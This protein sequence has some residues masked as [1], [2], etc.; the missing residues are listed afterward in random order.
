MQS[1]IKIPGLFKCQR[2]KNVFLTLHV[3]RNRCFS[4]SF[5][6]TRKCLQL[7]TD[8]KKKQFIVTKRLHLAT[9][10]LLKD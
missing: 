3:P 2:Q 4:D 1:F 5:K 7:S 8:N 10:R 9:A 6:L